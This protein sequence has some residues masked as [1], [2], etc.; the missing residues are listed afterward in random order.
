MEPKPVNP[1]EKVLI[2]FSDLVNL[3]RKAK[4]KVFL[5][6][7]IGIT[8]AS[9]YTLTRPIQ[10]VAEAT[11]R[12]KGKSSTGI[13]SSLTAL[14]F[15]NTAPTQG[16]EAI[17]TMKSRKVLEP[18]IREMGLQASFAHQDHSLSKLNTIYR[19]LQTS[20]AY[21]RNRQT[22]LFSDPESHLL[23]CEVIYK[24]EVPLNLQIAFTSENSFQVIDSKKKSWG[25]GVVGVP[26][27]H[28]GLE[29]TLRHNPS[30]K[31]PFKPAVFH[32]HLA[33]MLNVAKELAAAII[34]APEKKDATLLNLQ[35]PNSNRLLASQIVNNLMQGYHNY[36]QDSYDR[37]V[38]KQLAYLKE[39]QDGSYAQLKNEML[40]Q[41]TSLA[42]D[43]TTTGSLDPE[44]ELEFLS[45]HHYN[46]KK[47]LLEIDFEIKRIH[48]LQTESV[49]T[50]LTS[51]QDPAALDTLNE[52]KSLRQQRD[53]LMLA[54]RQAP[55]KD[56]TQIKQDF[57][58]QVR[59][60]EKVQYYLL[61]ISDVQAAFAN[62]KKAKTPLLSPEM[63][64]DPALM[65][66]IWH[67]EL[68]NKEIAWANALPDEKP[69]RH[70]QWS[71]CKANCS[72]YLANL[73][74]LY[75]VQEK[76]LKE[77]LALQH[78][79]PLEFQ[80]IDLASAREFYKNYSTQ[81]HETQAQIR[82]YAFIIEQLRDPNFEVTALSPTL[83]DSVSQAM[84]SKT[85]ELS[86]KL[87]DQRNRSDKEQARILE[88]LS[89]QRAFLI[90]HIDHTMQLT[91]LRENLIREKIQSLQS[92]TLELISQQLSISEQYIRDYLSTRIHSL[93]QER[94]LIEKQ[95]AK[96]QDTMA[97]LPK[98]WV[99]EQLIKLRLQQNTKMVEEISKLVETK[100]ITHN[101]EV[102]QSGPLDE[103][104]PLPLPKPRHLFFFALLGG[105]VGAALTVIFVILR[106]ILKGIPAS[107]ANLALIGQK[108][109][110]SL[111]R[112][113]A[114][115][116]HEPLLDQD[117]DTLRRL[118][119][120]ITNRKH[121]S[122]PLLAILGKG[123]DYID[124]LLHLLNAQGLKILYIDLKVNCLSSE[125]GI[126]DYLSGKILSIPL[127]K[128][129]AYDSI[130]AGS[131]TRH[132]N[133]LLK[134]SSFQ[135]LLGQLQPNYDLVIVASEALP[136]G[137]EA[138]SLFAMFQNIAITITD[139]PLPRLTYYTASANKNVVY[140]LAN[141]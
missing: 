125:P 127:Q 95:M 139:E 32:L 77:R 86:L 122:H 8:L 93:E 67:A 30:A 83:P 59:D 82:Q 80:G 132:T 47:R 13:P 136:L 45:Q 12:E 104:V 116:A 24:A 105:I 89:H 79:T 34:I 16:S 50:Y 119:A 55:G 88:D 21:W 61:A 84:I 69:L 60:L 35:Y 134:S 52:I 38:E 140:M 56:F 78:A 81:L 36:L 19:N 54:L 130:S 27:Q 126:F 96:L 110:G 25:T 49:H 41:A 46:I 3:C 29:F 33:P 98:K 107:E 40:A 15:N 123:P 91:G 37:Q 85:S 9:Y 71:N 53:S 39:R 26:F 68:L 111:T 113:A 66:G 51:I 121:P 94:S 101:L 42:E 117:L 75:L 92:T 99:G 62:E 137:A 2:A 58:Q 23:C 106:S 48:R 90:G 115:K 63:L 135:R 131:I 44:K 100:N 103:A 31:T 7:V 65:L 124:H 118:V 20:F 22:P 4:K 97:A 10:Y 17:S 128:R 87:K 1:P 109:A 141:A 114:S 5:G 138:E 133:E 14:L 64:Q 70:E 76:L 28:A 129:A 72:A 73:Q 120:S 112:R 18:L 102:I 43:I 108:V 57:A 74:N 11:F 6:A